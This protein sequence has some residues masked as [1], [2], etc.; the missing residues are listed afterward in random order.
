MCPGIDEIG[1]R[2]LTDIRGVV[3]E[4]SLKL[5][6]SFR[7]RVSRRV[8]HAFT[9]IELLVVIAI[10]SILAALLMPSLSQARERA[11]QMYCMNNLRQVGMATLLYADDNEGFVPYSSD[12]VINGALFGHVF[13]GVGIYNNYLPKYLNT[14]NQLYPPVSY[15]P[16]GGRDNTKNMIASDTNPNF[17]YAMNYYIQNQADP[18]FTKPSSAPQP[19][20]TVFWFETCYNGAFSASPNHI[21]GR[22]FLKSYGPSS[23]LGS[24]QPYG[25][26]NIL[27]CDLH[28]ESV[29]IPLPTPSIYDWGSRP[30]WRA[31][32]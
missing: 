12:V 22:H 10:I 3:F 24:P 7:G 20:Q 19:S 26:A 13:Y 11:R 9:L 18:D 15:C 4:N 6:N 5:K 21:A 16:S 25:A 28:L 1:G 32:P 31:R 2:I 17:S 29:R 30:F 23:G 14:Q 27:F 8:L